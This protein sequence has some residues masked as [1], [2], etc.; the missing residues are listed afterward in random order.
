MLPVKIILPIIGVTIVIAAVYD[1]FQTVF[2]PAA[3]G[4]FS[5]WI[6]GTVWRI[7]RR[8]GHRGM[9][10]AGPLA[11]V[12]TV[13]YWAGS[14]V[15][16]FGL[17]YAPYLPESFTFVQGL[18]PEGYRSFGAALDVSLCSLMTLSTGAYPKNLWIQMSM[19]IESLLGFALLTASVSW[20]LSIY[21]VLEHR[22]SLAQCATLLHY[23]E[24]QG[25]R[26]LDQ[27][28]DSDLSSILQAIVSQLTT[29]RNELMQFPITYY[30]Y[31][32]D[33]VTALPGVL[34]YLADIARESASRDG[35]AAI[36]AVSLGGAIDDYLKVL[37]RSFLHRRFK[38]RDEAMKAYAIDHR[39]EIVRSPTPGR[40]AA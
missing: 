19:G 23:S 27:I 4:G 21:P 6:S 8:F 36:S 10:L 20:M 18:A 17:V 24:E 1:L 33:K 37:E 40:K 26:R 13:A 2:H 5:D 16:G 15:F 7:L 28:S 29:H 12:M 34:P 35:A 30:F 38:T 22:R 32:E 11:F 3:N 39:R 14:L 25:I 9:L 31:E